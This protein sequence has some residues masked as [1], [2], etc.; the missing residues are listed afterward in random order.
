[1]I[2]SLNAPENHESV[3]GFGGVDILA[4]SR[5]FG[6]VLGSLSLFVLLTTACVSRNHQV[7]ETRFDNLMDVSKTEL[8]CENVKHTPLG[9][10]LHLVQGCG[11]QASYL[12]YC[13]LTSC[14]W[15]QN[16]GELA[17]ASM[18]CPPASIRMRRLNRATYE[19]QGCGERLRYRLKGRDW[20]VEDS[21]ETAGR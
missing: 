13:Y 7:T 5:L 1:V 6:P 19:F 16:P 2:V 11:R 3:P 17:V 12:L 18:G 14:R 15:V 21:G 9:N 20:Q 10:D 8:R 4:A